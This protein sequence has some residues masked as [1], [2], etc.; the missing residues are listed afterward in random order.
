MK[1]QPQHDLIDPEVPPPETDAEPHGERDPGAVGDAYVIGEH[2]NT[3]QVLDAAPAK[4]SKRRS[5]AWVQPLGVA[6][7]VVFVGLTVWN[8]SR[9]LG[10]PPPP[11]T[12]SPFQVKQ[13]LY[14]GVMRID[15]YRR[16]HG[17]TPS[18]LAEAGLPEDGG[19]GYRRIDPQ[20][21]A[22]SF[23]GNGPTLEY[24][25]SIPKDRFFGAPQDILSMGGSK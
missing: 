23:Q 15:A 17:V 22:V 6:L 9:L 21:Y 4:K 25:S 1:Y 13:A 12:P 24:D 19:Y 20:R 14:L 7:G 18:S 16:V 10:D 2:G 5:K 8:L 11:P 3:F